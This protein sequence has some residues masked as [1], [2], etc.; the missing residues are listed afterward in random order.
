MV[1]RRTRIEQATLA[2]LVLCLAGAARALAHWGVADIEPR[3]K[4]H[5]GARP[6]AGFYD[7][8]ARG[9]HAF[10]FRHGWLERARAVRQNRAALRARGAF[11]LMNAQSVML[12]ASPQAATAVSGTLRY[13]TFMPFFTN[14]SQADSALMDSATVQNKFWGT[15]PA[16][17]YSITTYY[18]EISGNRL[19]VTGNVIGRGFRVSHMGTFYSGGSAC[20]GLCAA[21]QVDSLI[22]EILHHADSTVDFS[23]YAD[24]TDGHVP[25]VVILDPQVGA[26]CYQVYPPSDSSIWAHRF[27]LSGWQGFRRGPGRYVTNDV[28]NGHAVFIDDYIIQG[29]QGEGPPGSAQG[30]ECTP[31]YLA[32]IGTVT[33]ETG[34]LFGLPD[35]YDVSSNNATEG[36]GHWDLMSSGNEQEPNRPAHMSA[37]SLSFLGWISEVP[38]TTAQT[39]TTGPIEVSDTA[40]IVPIAGT[41]DNEFFL[42]ENRQPIGSDSMIH[43]PGLLIYH[44]DTVLI[45]QRMSNGNNVVNA[46][47]PHGLWILEAAG[48][49]GLFCVYPAAC[50]DRGDAGD[51]F[52][53]SSNNTTLG[54]GTRPA[55]ITNAGAVAGVIIDSIQ[56]VVPFGAMRFRVRFGGVTV[57]KASQTGAQVRVDGVAMQQYQNV[58]TNGETHTISVDALQTSAD[59]RTQYLFQSWSDRGA[60]SHTI[61][62]TGSTTG[63]TYVATVGSQ[64]LAKYVVVGGGSVGASPAVDAVNGAFFTAG[65]SV[66]LTATAAAGQ[67]FIGWSGDTAASAAVLNLAMTRPFTV[68]A[69]FAATSDVVNQLLK[70]SSA[71][72]PAA[73]QLLDQLGNN[74]GRFDVGDLVAWLDRNPGLATSPAVL[75]LLRRI[76]L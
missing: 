29:G 8:A 5:R 49:T 56:Q 70:G 24:S 46:L 40:F 27:S 44:A 36:L 45:N 28:I 30:L 2:A 73:L 19:T 57:V 35:L 4:I 3:A 16:P 9:P 42:L 32:P 38:V 13:P 11:N 20:Q 25:A 47:R 68:T 61:I 39:I 54:P 43:G 34:H 59:G 74:N 50:D 55:A 33:H 26:E 15:A 23:P 22:R 60:R 48:D 62:G 37:W 6:P 53:G 67:S 7:M 58:L 51:P 72:A 10:E 64:Y 14:T 69:D 76:H 63:T 17:P 18:R 21:A 65:G 71:I 66:T 12:A 75:K 41:P 52:P 1:R 31:G